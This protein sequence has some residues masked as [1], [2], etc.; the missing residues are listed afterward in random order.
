MPTVVQTSIILA[1]LSTTKKE[2]KKCKLQS[3]LNRKARLCSHPIPFIFSAPSFLF[4]ISSIKFLW[5]TALLLLIVRFV[6]FLQELNILLHLWSLV[7][8]WSY[9]KYIVLQR[10]YTC[11]CYETFKIIATGWDEGKN[12][13]FYIYSERV[14][15]VFSLHLVHNK[16][17]HFI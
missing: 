11:C 14:M 8:F 6:L 2:Q 3:S 1:V 4:S 15:V 9:S 7:S 16:L 12:V 10:L 17:Q 5:F 13:S